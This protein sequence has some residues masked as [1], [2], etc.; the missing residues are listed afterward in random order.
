[1]YLEQN[2]VAILE[3]SALV[4]MFSRRL[5]KNYENFHFIYNGT[6]ISY[7]AKSVFSNLPVFLLT[8]FNLINNNLNVE[9]I[10]QSVGDE[11]TKKYLRNNKKGI[12]DKENH[13]PI[14][15]ILCNFFLTHNEV[16]ENN[17]EGNLKRLK[18]L[19]D[20]QVYKVFNE[21]IM[22]LKALQTI[23]SEKNI[24]EENFEVFSEAL[25]MLNNYIMLGNPILTNEIFKVF[26]A[27]IVQHLT[28]EIF[29]IICTSLS[30]FYYSFQQEI[31]GNPEPWIE[32]IMLFLTIIRQL[33]V[34]LVEMFEDSDPE[35]K[36][37]SLAYD[38][39]FLN[40]MLTYLFSG[41]PRLQLEGVRALKQTFQALVD[42]S[43]ASQNRKNIVGGCLEKFIV[44]SLSKFGDEN[45]P[46]DIKIRM[47]DLLLF[48]ERITKDSFK[49]L[50][51]LF[52][53]TTF[54]ICRDADLVRIYLFNLR[55][56]WRN[57]KQ[58]TV[59]L[60]PKIIAF[61]KCSFE[62]MQAKKIITTQDN[63]LI[64]EVFKLFVYL[65]FECPT[66]NKFSFPESL[67]SFIIISLD[68]KVNGNVLTLITQLMQ[69]LYSNVPSVQVKQML[70]TLTEDQRKVLCQI[71]PILQT[72]NEQ[73]ID[74]QQANV[75]GVNVGQATTEKPVIKLK[76]FGKK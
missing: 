46:Q 60:L 71:I 3:D 72:V 69:H 31:Q 32:T 22:I 57:A 38:M 73:K 23:L 17:S 27:I 61:I 7:D 13:I 70:G 24:V 35:N 54:M 28:I 68:L 43:K 53:E 34:K 19:Y 51:S 9:D 52:D 20:F 37:L 33:M 15:L 63:E 40:I 47:M 1:M 49:N 48:M 21:K 55:N 76:A 2:L 16:Y 74:T 12:P 5:L 65:Q 44:F 39:Y 10:I 75:T 6:K 26:Q 25:N 62:Q 18:K 41:I 11:E 58:I 36:R 30:L 56:L 45:I 4:V 50:A 42:V 64:A 59:D 67:L 8:Y 66:V 29:E 14:C